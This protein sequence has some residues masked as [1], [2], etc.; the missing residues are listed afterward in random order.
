MLGRI[1]I[2]LGGFGFHRAGT[3]LE[4]LK[5]LLARVNS[6]TEQTYIGEPGLATAEAGERMLKE[7]VETAMEL[8]DKA[9]AGEKPCTRPIL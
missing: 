3:E 6:P 7:H 5:N 1:G 9:P 8:L 2:I 4:H